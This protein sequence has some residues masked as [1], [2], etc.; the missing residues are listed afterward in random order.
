[1]R[2]NISIAGAATAITVIGLILSLGA[3]YTKKEYKK[4]LVVI[5]SLLT[6]Y[7]VSNL[8]LWNVTDV[9]GYGYM[10][11]SYI[12]LFCESLFSSMILPVLNKFLLYCTEKNTRKHPLFYTTVL[13]WLVYFIFLVTDQFTK[14]IYYYTP[15]NEYFR[16]PLYFVLLIPLALLMAVNLFALFKYHAKLSQRFGK[17][18]RRG[19][20]WTGL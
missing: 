5:F 3:R 9:K 18:D 14:W 12:C 16:G 17:R 6:A 4:Y 20:R 11:V 10:I 1:M 19:G 15:D 13:L 8:I 7:T 2:A